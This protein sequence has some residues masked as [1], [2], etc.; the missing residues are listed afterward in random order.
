MIQL[1]PHWARHG[2]LSRKKY[3]SYTF[4]LRIVWSKFP[5][6]PSIRKLSLNNCVFLFLV[7]IIYLEFKSF[8]ISF[9]Q[10][11]IKKRLILSF[12]NFAGFSIFLK[13]VCF[14]KD[15]MQFLSLSFYLL[16]TLSRNIPKHFSFRSNSLFENFINNTIKCL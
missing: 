10:R 1:S 4:I 6:I 7:A 2:L 12:G 11:F 15:K 9:L 3:I 14:I 16:S 5:R 8:V 13:I